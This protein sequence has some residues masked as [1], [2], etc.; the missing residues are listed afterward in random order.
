MQ[1]TSSIRHW[2]DEAIQALGYI[3]PTSASKIVELIEQNPT[4]DPKAIA[5]RYRRTGEQI[6][7]DEKRRLGIRANGFMSKAA[8]ADLS[9]IGLE[10]PL[11]GHQLT[12]LRAVLASGRALSIE[13]EI[14]LGVTE[15]ECITPFPDKCAGCAR[16]SATT[17]SPADASPTGPQDCFREACAISYIGK[18]D[19]LAEIDPAKAPKS[20]SS[21]KERPWWKLW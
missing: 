5:T 21:S 4:E 20:Q 6:T 1:Y 15:F 13:G 17:M 16:L 10:A 12:I 19:F 18:I 11:A 2:V 9:D 8:L 3:K 14:Q 7:L